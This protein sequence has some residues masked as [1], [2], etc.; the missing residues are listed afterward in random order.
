MSE[1]EEW[2]RFP[3]KHASSVYIDECVLGSFDKFTILSVLF[4]KENKSRLST[5]RFF[6]NNSN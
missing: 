3:S 5:D 2:L 4:L 6:F 1:L